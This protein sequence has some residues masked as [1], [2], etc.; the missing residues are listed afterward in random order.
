MSPEK[1][2]ST[3]SP[4]DAKSWLEYSWKIQQQVPNRFEDA[5]KFLVTIVC[6]VMTLFVTSLNKLKSITD[7]HLILAFIFLFWLAALFFAFMVLFPHRYTFPSKS[8]EQIKEMQKQI[9][10]RKKCYFYISV[11]FF[12]IPFIVFAILIFLAT[13]N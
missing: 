3:F 7:H 9:V 12:F 11:V 4:P 2:Q 10:K 1:K 8:V 13:I 6:I 5:A